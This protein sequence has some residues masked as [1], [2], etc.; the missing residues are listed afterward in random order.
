VRSLAL[1]VV[2]MFSFAGH[3]YG[4][5]YFDFCPLPAAGSSPGTVESVRAVPVPRDLHAFDAEVLEH[6][7]VPEM[8]DEIVVQLD[9]GPVV[10]FTEKQAH[11]VH[12]GERV[13][14]TLGGSSARVALES[15]ECATPLALEAGAQRLF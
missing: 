15:E 2:A 10:I 4:Q 12:A 3:A 11:R 14:V 7:V 6:K 13:R 8:V 1:L 9:A 5:Q